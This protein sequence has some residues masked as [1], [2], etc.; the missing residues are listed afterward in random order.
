MAIELGKA[1][2]ETRGIM[3]GSVQDSLNKPRPIAKWDPA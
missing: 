3:M 1:T 2:V